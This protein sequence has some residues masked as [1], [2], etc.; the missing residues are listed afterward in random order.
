MTSPREFLSPCVHVSIQA[1]A[2]PTR[3]VGRAGY[4]MHR[5]AH[6]FFGGTAPNFAYSA[7]GAELG[8][9]LVAE[10]L[11]ATLLPDFSVAGDPL[12]RAG[13][14][15]L[16]PLADETT[17]VLLVLQRRR[18]DAAPRAIRVLSDTL[19]TQA[20]RLRE[21]VTSSRSSALDL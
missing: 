11:G 16:R 19:R 2:P 6:R 17:R 18:G 3:R 10:G 5:Y 12:E 15:T 1:A 7:D 21:T 8:K 4:V 9:L 13:L 14:I 20:A